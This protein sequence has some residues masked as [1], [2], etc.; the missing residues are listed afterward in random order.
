MSAEIERVVVA[1][2]T[3]PFN[4]ELNF[5][6]AVEYEKLD[7][8]ASAVSFYL[9]CAEFG[10][11]THSVFVYNSLLKMANCFEDQKERQWT[12]SNYL[13]QAAEYYPTR[14]E[15]WFLLSRFHER[16]SNW[17]ESYTFA[18]VGL[19][20]GYHSHPQPLPSD[21]GYPGK[22]ALEF[23]KAVAGWWIGRRDESK[24][25]FD[26]LLEMDIQQ[27]YRDAIKYNM[28]RLA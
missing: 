9:R 2:S 28:E 27:D 17:Q 8:L 16:S 10:Y 6:A 25:I 5:R 23:Q 11:G 24:Q 22:Y 7:Q 19:S 12:V 21:V 4:P 14:P 26:G 20:L 3:D 18:G 1:L 13:L 15:A